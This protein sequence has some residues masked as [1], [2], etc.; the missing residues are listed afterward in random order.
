MAVSVLSPQPSFVDGFQVCYSARDAI[1]YA[2]SIGLGS[3]SSA[4]D[5]KY[6]Y[7]RDPDFQVFPLFGLSL[8]FWATSH[9]NTTT[10]TT[11]FLPPFP[12]PMMKAMAII[13]KD[14]LR[15][16]DAALEDYPILH[17]FQSIVWH[18]P[19]PVPAPD[20]LSVLNIKGR[21][22]SIQPKP[23]GSFVTTELVVSRN[24]TALVCTLLSTALVLGLAPDR[25][26]AYGDHISRRP[27]LK[28]YSIWFQSKPFALSPNCALFYRVASGDTNRIHVEAHLLPLFDSKQP[29]LHGLCAL[30]IAGRIILQRLEMENEYQIVLLRLEGGFSKPVFVGDQISVKVWRKFTGRGRC[31]RVQLLFEVYNV[32]KKQVAVE[33][34]YMVA[35]IARTL[36]TIETKSRL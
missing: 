15:N 19:L 29:L 8:V 35:E 17:T 23:I 7:E 16:S 11:S 30:G 18:G 27:Q 1:L 5:L 12:P 34:G 22:V 9:H 13:P 32:V 26:I 28:D 36:P 6:L 14:Y 24:E 31:E 2:L 3:D 20:K 10:T 21:C 33:R 4:L 25:V